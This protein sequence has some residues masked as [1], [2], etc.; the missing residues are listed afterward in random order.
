MAARLSALHAGC[1]LPPGLFI[2]EDSWHSFLLRGWVNPRAIMRP[3]GLGQFKNPPHRDLNPRPSSLQYSARQSYL[4]KMPWQ[5]WC[6]LR[7]SVWLEFYLRVWF[8]SPKILF[9][10]SKWLSELFSDQNIVLYS[11]FGSVRCLILKR[12]VTLDC[13][14]MVQGLFNTHLINLI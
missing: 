14:V 1:T 9:Y 8:L 12:G 2:F 6:S 7:C 11:R 10:E 3:E 4:Q 5:K 13:R